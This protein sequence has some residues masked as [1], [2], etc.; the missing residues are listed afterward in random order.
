[1]ITERQIWAVV[2]AAGIGTRFS[3]QRIKQYA[4]IGN[5]TVLEHSVTNLLQHPSIH[6]IVIALHPGDSQ[7]RQLPLLQ[8]EKISFVEGGVERADSVLQA[9]LHLNAYADQGDWIL[10]HDA[11]RPCVSMQDIHNLISALSDDPVGG[12]LAI[13]ATDTLKTVEA[14][15]IVRTIDRSLIWQ[16]QTPQMFRFGMLLKCLQLAKQNVQLIT[17]EASAIEACGYAP[18]VILGSRSNI[19]ITYPDDLALAA[20]YFLQESSR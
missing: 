3:D 16:A 6:K 14:N 11:A 8:H 19:K 13:P 20:F 18:K 12:I 1:M 7:G 4:S 5:A 2:P 9:L 15:S 17:D 10:V